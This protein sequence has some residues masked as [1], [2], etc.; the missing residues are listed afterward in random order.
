MADINQQAT[1]QIEV[2]SESAKRKIA[3]LENKLV[4]LNKKKQEFEKTGNTAGL[5]KIEKE[6]Q[7]VDRQMNNARTNAQKCEAALKK[8]SSASPKE[9]R[10]TL[11]QLQN[12]LNHI[13]RGS[14]AWNEHVQAIKRVKAEINAVDAELKEHQSLLQR[15]NNFVN[16]WGMSLA[17]A[18]ASFTG[19]VFTARKAVE[20]FADMDAEMANVQKFTGMTTDQVAALN[21][22]FKKM[23]TRTSREEL[24]KLAQEAGRLG[25]QTQEEVLGFVKAADVINVALDD[26]GDGA[27]LTLSKLTDI[28]GDK[29]RYGVEDS[30]LKVG[31]VINE[32]SQNCTASAPYLADFAQ[33]LAGVGKQA[34]MTIPEIMGLAAVLDSNGQAVE[35]SA[36]AVSQLIMKMF[37]DPAKIAQAT[38]LSLQEFSRVLKEDTNQALIMLLEQLNSLGNLDVLAPVFAAMGTDGARASQVIAALAGNINMVKQ[39]QQA[40]TTAFRQGNSV[41]KEFNVQNNTAKANLDKAKKGFN[42]VAVALGQKLAPAMKH[43]VTGTSAL[44]RILLQVINFVSKYAGTIISLT[45]AIGGY[46]VVVNA[47]IIADKLKVFWNE[48]V[49]ASFKNLWK[50]IVANPYAALAAA[51]GVIIGLIID[52]T[53]ATNAEAEAE[54]TLNDI[55]KTAAENAAEEQM[56]IETLMATA[57]NMTIAYEDQYAACAALNKLIPNFNGKIDAQ[58][59][60]FTYSASALDN[61]NKQLMRLYELEGAREKLKELGRRRADK[62]LEIAAIKE[63]LKNE[64][65]TNGNFNY[66]TSQGNG[67]PA[68]AHMPARRSALE[69]QLTKANTELAGIDAGVKA[70]QKQ[71]GSDMYK[72]SAGPKPETPTSN[73]TGGGGGGGGGGNNSGTGGKHGSSGGNHRGGGGGNNS[74]TGGKHGSSGGNHRGGGGGH[75]Q[76]EE[77]KKRQQEEEKRKR[78]QEILAKQDFKTAF[79]LLKSNRIKANAA[80]LESYRKGEIDYEAY[81]KKL[82]AASEEYYTNAEAL[83]KKY[84]ISDS[85]EAAKMNEKRIQEQEK[86]YS[87]LKQLQQDAL[88]DRR[89]NAQIQAE[90]DFYDSSN[91]AAYK[92]EELKNAK[93]AKLNLEYYRDMLD[94][95]TEG[96]KEY[97]EAERAYIKAAK[98]EELRQRQEMEEHLQEWL[99]TY[100]LLG[101]EQRMEMELRVAAALYKDKAD[102]EE[103]YQQVRAA[104]IK[105]Y[106]DLVNSETGTTA[107]GQG[108]TDAAR[109]RDDALAKLEK[110][111]KEGLLDGEEDYQHRRWQI[112]KAYHDKVK[113]LVSSE[114]NEWGTMVTNLVE[115]FK[116]AFDNMGSNLADI[117]KSIEDMAAATFAILG[118]GLESWSNYSN[119]Q[120]DLEIANINKNYDEK[121]KAAGNNDK[122][123]KKLEEQKQAE[124]AKVKNKYNKRAQAIEMAQAVAS[125]AMAAINAYAS[126]AQVPMIG[127]II[128]PIAASLALAAGALQIATIRKQ[129]QAEAA[130]YYEGG[131][132][133]RDRDNHREVGVVHANEFVANHEAVANPQL[134]PVLRLIDQ[135]QR[136][137]T[138]GSL[139]SE[140]VSRALGQGGILGE[141][142]SNQQR[143][144]TER[145]ASMALVAAAMEQQSAAIVEL[146]RRLEQGIESFMVM[147]GERGFEK[148]WENYQALKERPRR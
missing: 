66:S 48:K 106:N 62:I 125:T 111:K 20:A 34:N 82:H 64:P 112:I 19:L 138:V 70:I 94:L 142:T 122:K 87:D 127:Y 131:F 43:I 17:S 140:D 18:A 81:L 114:G 41:I 28:F 68:A 145:E 90:L 129:H 107:Q 2:N 12:D 146:N 84:E 118:A 116:N 136:N 104:I 77:E 33:R 124:I 98:E 119:A 99:T 10:M 144:L 97:Y 113:E 110:A 128:A 30:L 141:M 25:M 69:A 15:A 14:K 56:K 5:V 79:E 4:D 39:Q 101:A 9:L 108:F 53:R 109:E 36:T 58:K 65:V 72:Q 63:E 130:G 135:A 115:S 85:E 88:A 100:N 23:D 123:T 134:A 117:L 126:A 75:T 76:T 13:E 60:K 32:L 45:T 24:N 26:L 74:G 132:T 22:E 89:D 31:S 29:M 21:E 102:K 50:I 6:L 8:L 47:S 71:Y 80:A 147:D 40:A 105:K 49:L 54:A 83:F 42:E 61:Y 78:Q 44:M 73:I 27:T 121:I 1:V 133:S 3:E 91:A 67:A 103:E 148:Y 120:R 57:N 95:E 55:R 92:N 51:I 52:L 139:T 93:L 7:K 143:S 11:R 38:G 137:N 86:Y 16:K 37:K 59:R 46:I 35:M 96:T